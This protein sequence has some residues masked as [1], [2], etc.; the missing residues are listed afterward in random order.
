MHT[1]ILLVFNHVHSYIRIYTHKVMQ[2]NYPTCKHICNYKT[3]LKA[4]IPSCTFTFVY[5]L[6]YPLPHTLT[7]YLTKSFKQTLIYELISTDIFLIHSSIH[8]FIHDHSLIHALCIYWCI[9]IY[10]HSSFVHMLICMSTRTCQYLQYSFL[11]SNTM[12]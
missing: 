8:T 3:H 4:L 5:M 1:L 12:L 2:S 6:T 7:N 9:Y 10:I 11:I